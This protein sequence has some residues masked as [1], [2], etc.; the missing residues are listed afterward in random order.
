MNLTGTLFGIIGR[1][2]F[3]AFGVVTFLVSGLLATVN[4]TSRYALKTYVD[5]QLRRTPWDVALYQRSSISDNLVSLPRRLSRLPTLEQV[6]VRAFLR[7]RFPDTGEV[8][9]E[10]D[11]L[12]LST[13]WLSLL[14]A[15][16]QS[17]L[18]PQVNLALGSRTSAAAADAPPGAVLAL[19]GP[20]RYMGQ[21][22]M[23]LQGAKEFTINVRGENSSRVL[24]RIPVKSVIRLDRDELNRWLMDQ[25]GSLTFVPFI[26]AMLL[27]PYDPAIISLFDT[28]A[29][30]MLPPEMRAPGFSDH[31]QRAE[32]TPELVYLARYRRHD[33]I[34]GWDIAGSLARVEAVN[35]QVHDTA[36]SPDVAWF[37]G[38]SRRQGS[39]GVRLV[40]GEDPTS[41]GDNAFFVDSTTEVL[42]QRM[43]G[44]ARL[45]GLVTLLVALPLLWM[46]WMLAANLVGLLMLN[47]RRLLGLMRL[48]GVPGRLLGRTL[49]QAI[50]A[51]GFIG[52]VLG[53]VAGSVGPLLV[54]EH[55]R[56]PLDVLMQP[57][58]L[59]LSLLFL[60]IT[61]VLALMVSLRL[62][63]YATT[64][65]PLEA[66]GRVAM[67][68]VSQASIRF[69]PLQGLSLALGAYVLVRW[70]SGISLSARFNVQPVFLA[71]RLLDFL[72]LPLFV[73]GVATLLASREQWIR[74]S[75][76][77]LMRPLG[78]SL[79]PF[80]LNHMSVKPHRTM[81]FLFIV[82][83][84]SSVSLYPTIT[85]GSFEDRALRGAKVQLGTEWQLMYNTPDFV[86]ASK[87]R[88]DLS[89]ELAALRP[90]LDRLLTRMKAIEGVQDATYMVEAILPSFYLP[91]YGLR[92]VPLY[93]VNGTDAYLKNVYSE[94]EVGVGASFRDV[95]TPM[96]TGGVASSL[97]VAD[98]WQL[99][100]GTDLLLG[101]SRGRDSVVARASGALAYLPG[102]PPRS[103][104]DR[105]G[106]VQ[107]RVDYLNYLFS[108]NAYV[109]GS[110]ESAEL[111]KLV[112]LVPRVIVLVKV[113]DGAPKEPMRAALLGV[114]SLPPL[115]M[116]NIEDEVGKLGTDMYIS[117]AL[118]NI[119]IYLLGGLLLALIAIIAVGMA[120]YAED[121]KTLALLR[122][123]GASPRQIFRFLMAMLLS[124]A[125]F[126]LVLGMIVALIAGHGLAT[127]VWQLREI[128]TVVQLLPT[129]LV[130][131]SLSLGVAGVILLLL[132]GV[133]LGLSLWEFRRSAHRSVSGV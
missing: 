18:P 75:M 111:G 5:D 57:H 88:G 14:A 7:A 12:P 119:R 93:L 79:G 46:A 34:S 19:V 61:L 130:V 49:I 103:V 118:A 112:A 20:E 95:V 94:P 84:M 41:S 68:E 10:V 117:L 97:P 106:Y 17:V 96:Q 48:R 123:R 31:V 1:R 72:A 125:I 36:E 109:V 69:G 82:A 39:G 101:M 81:A 37:R 3:I 100:R 33:L 70:A 47:E 13:P 25:T 51:G 53:L 116:H 107:A 73:Y 80:A 27:M 104:N 60:V 64:I 99:S 8:F 89:T 87:L 120:N 32:Y 29:S 16:N 128:R 40:H 28:V 50:V 122:V 59:A 23:T 52:G 38:G 102:L 9:T 15:S 6:E 98:F 24:F 77:P 58:Q 4:L 129:R 66:S 71:E 131:S 22:F 65:S 44:I 115:E 113:R 92:G 45:V 21:A 63:R 121:Q 30:G 105:Q 55:G 74:R 83:L 56:L 133:A 43:A 76:A 42:L 91:G 132:V 127:Y 11:G 54:Y 26:G 67:T 124:P 90:E 85:G 35:L 62:I 86:D 110:T 114:S 108:S 2:P 126:G 78:G